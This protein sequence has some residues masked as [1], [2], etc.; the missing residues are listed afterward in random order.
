MERA[1]QIVRFMEENDTHLPALAVCDGVAYYPDTKKLAAFTDDRF[2]RGLAASGRSPVSKEGT[3]MRVPDGEVDATENFFRVIEGEAPCSLRIQQMIE[4]FAITKY[5]MADSV[6]ELLPAYFAAAMQQMTAAEVPPFSATLCLHCRLRAHRVRSALG[7]VQ[8]VIVFQVFDRGM[9]MQLAWLTGELLVHVADRADYHSTYVAFLAAAAL[10]P[11]IA[12]S[13]KSFHEYATCMLEQARLAASPQTCR[14]HADVAQAATL[15]TH[16]RFLHAIALASVSP[17]ENWDEE[18]GEDASAVLGGLLADTC[19]QPCQH[20]AT[21]SDLLVDACMDAPRSRTAQQRKILR[22][23]H[24]LLLTSHCEG[25]NLQCLRL[26]APG[27]PVV[28]GKAGDREMF[29]VRLALPS[30]ASRPTETQATGSGWWLKLERCPA[31]EE[32]QTTFSLFLNNQ[33]ACKDSPMQASFEI[34]IVS[35]C[36]TALCKAEAAAALIDH[37]GF[38]RPGL[39]SAA[40]AAVHRSA[41]RQEFG[42][43]AWGIR[44]LFDDQALARFGYDVSSEQPVFLFG[45]VQSS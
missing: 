41:I 2:F 12:A 15:P 11:G 33:H 22:S 42:G 25:S 14:L 35:C 23:S 16:F 38:M 8:T 30:V 45:M 1:T 4:L 29:V 13:T 20:A 24:R 6:V 28:L 43:T 37:V 44:H 9:R 32:S 40:E 31:G 5:Y 26:A 3:C 10:S 39:W 21:L 17:A 18:D 19:A 36:S 7:D 27:K 34:G